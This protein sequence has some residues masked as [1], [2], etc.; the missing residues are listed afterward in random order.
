[1]RPR[2]GTMTDNRS[3]HVSSTGRKQWCLK[4]RHA[5]RTSKGVLGDTETEGLQPVVEL[6]VVCRCVSLHTPIVSCSLLVQRSDHWIW[7]HGSR[8]SPLDLHVWL[9]QVLLQAGPLDDHSEGSPQGSTAVAATGAV[10]RGPA[11]KKHSGRSPKRRGHWGSTGAGQP[12]K[13]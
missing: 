8:V 3:R 9:V 5:I 2:I 12:A 1:M 7:S 4:W 13:V 6:R 10:D 11:T